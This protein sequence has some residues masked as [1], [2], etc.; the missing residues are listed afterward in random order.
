M[1][2]LYFAWLRTEIG[3]AEESASP[4]ASIK[5]AGALIDWLAALSPGH[6]AAFEKRDSIRVAI[7][8]EFAELDSCLSGASEVA[9]FPPVTGG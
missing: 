1:K 2:I 8:Q 6:A 7:D 3:L 5:T 4:P 9:F